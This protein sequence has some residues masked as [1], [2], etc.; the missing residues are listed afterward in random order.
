MGG[1]KARARVCGDMRG[2][3]FEKRKIHS[4]VACN[5]T[6]EEDDETDVPFVSGEKRQKRA[7]QGEI[8]WHEEGQ[9]E[10]VEEGTVR[11]AGTWKEA[12]EVIEFSEEKGYDL[13][14]MSTLWPGYTPR[15][16]VRGEKTRVKVEALS[17][18][19]LE[20]TLGALSRET[21]LG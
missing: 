5:D 18:I 20:T 11:Q 3:R 8:V 10:K 13:R 6:P 4:C 14:K 9:V 16:N 2:E 17:E 15:L 21:G 7:G 1:R 19:Q 12:G